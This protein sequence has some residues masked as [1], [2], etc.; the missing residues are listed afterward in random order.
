M[1]IDNFEN[2]KV[3]KTYI[4]GRIVAQNGLSLLPR[5]KA[6][7]VNQ[8]KVKPKKPADFAVKAQTGKIKVIEVI[9]GE[10]ITKKITVEPKIVDGLVVSDPERDIL[11]IAVVNRYQDAPPAVAFIKNF[12]L[13]WGCP[14]LS[15]GS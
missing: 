2:F 11:K 3:M 10:L 12:G 13:K 6:G 14:C 7:V 15:S 5:V 4:N 8:F 9:D 1:V